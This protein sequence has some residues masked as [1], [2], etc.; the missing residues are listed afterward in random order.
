M[1]ETAKAKFEQ[2][3][4]EHRTFLSSLLPLLPEPMA[5]E[6]FALEVFVEL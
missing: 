4:N 1:N 5:L 6:E 2:F 3:L